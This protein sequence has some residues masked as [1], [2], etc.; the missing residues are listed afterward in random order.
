MRNHLY[1][2]YDSCH[3]NIGYCGVSDRNRYDN[4]ID[5]VIYVNCYKC[6]DIAVELGKKCAE[7]LTELP[8]RHS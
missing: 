5:A 2:E 1:H 3:G 4:V 7:R 8:I 6:L